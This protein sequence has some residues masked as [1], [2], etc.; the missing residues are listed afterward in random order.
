MALSVFAAIV[1]PLLNVNVLLLCVIFTLLL[2]KLITPPVPKYKSSHPN[3]GAPR[4]YVAS[5]LGTIFEAISPLNVILFD[6]LAPKVTSPFVTKLLPIV[7][8]P[9]VLSTFNALDFTFN[10]AFNVVSPVTVKLP[11]KLV[12]PVPTVNVFVP[13][14]LVVP[15][16]VLLPVT[17]KLPFDI[18][19]LPD[20]IVTFP[21][22]TSIPSVAT[23]N[24][25]P[26]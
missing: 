15:L 19:K 1:L 2:P 23:I 3:V 25:F 18:V 13:V 7:V 6:E 9:L 26:P 21:L 4:L 17:S 22:K 5:T 16:K 20:V 10:P 11:P 8:T 14:T 24:F 12:A